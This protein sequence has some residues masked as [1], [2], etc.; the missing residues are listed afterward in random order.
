MNHTKNLFGEAEENFKKARKERSLI[1]HSKKDIINGQENSL[2]QMFLNRLNGMPSSRFV[3][4]KRPS[5]Q[6]NSEAIT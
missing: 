4:V 2:K 5:K 6:H 1:A 3:Q